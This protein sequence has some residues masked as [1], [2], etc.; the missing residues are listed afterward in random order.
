MSKVM[1]TKDVRYEMMDYWTIEVV[2]ALFDNN[3]K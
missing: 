3:A 1:R 2:H